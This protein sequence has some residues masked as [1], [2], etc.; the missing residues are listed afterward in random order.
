[1]LQKGS[2]DYKKAQKLANKIF[3]WAN[4]YK[5]SSEYD[6]AEIDI[7]EVLDTAIEKC[8]GFGVEVAKTVK[9]AL[10][11]FLRVDANSA[12]SIFAY[13]PKAPKKLTCFKY[14]K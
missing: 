7:E 12:A 9:T 8:Q 13:Q 11:L 6:F 14:S 5:G 2:Q 4:T 10:N 3:D 1:M